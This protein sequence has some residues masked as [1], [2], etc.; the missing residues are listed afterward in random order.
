M[1]MS[2]QE[3]LEEPYQREEPNVC[4]E[5]GYPKCRCHQ[6]EDREDR[7]PTDAEMDKVADQYEKGITDPFPN[8]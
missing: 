7:D 6:I 4:D 5:C 2:H 1:A 8:L 3:Y